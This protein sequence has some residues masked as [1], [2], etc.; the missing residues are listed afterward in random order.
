MKMYSIKNICRV[1]AWLLL[2]VVTCC[3]SL[4][5]QTVTVSA[6]KTATQLANALTGPGVTISN[7]TLNCPSGANGTFS[8]ASSPLLINNGILLTTGSA[9]DVSNPA[10][11]FENTNNNAAGDASLT[12]LSGNPTF[13]ACVLEFDFVPIGDSI[14]FRYQFASEEY[15]NYTCTE[16][17]DV[18]G[19]FISGPGYAVPTNIARVPGTMVPVAINSVNGGTPTGEGELTN[20]TAMGPGSP[21]PAYFVNNAS[22]ATM[23]YDG[24]T[25]VLSA[26]AAVTPC[27]TYHFKLGVAD[28][29]DRVLSS[30]VFIEEGSLAILP[31]AITNCPAN[32]TLYAGTTAGSCEKVAT[33]TPPSVSAATCLNVTS[34]SSHLPGGLFKVGTTPVTYSFTNAGGTS[35]CTFNVTV[36]DTVKPVAVCKNNIILNLDSGMGAVTPMMVNNGSSDNCGIMSMTVTPAQFTCEDAGNQTVTLTVTDSSGNT[37]TCTTTVKVRYAPSCSISVMPSSNTYTGGIPTNIYLGYGPQKATIKANATGGTG[38]TYSWSPANN[39][40][41]TTCKNPVFKPTA[42]GTYVYEVTVT[43]SNGCSTTCSVVF[44]VKD[45]RVP[46]N[47]NHNN[48]SW[49]NGWWC[50]GGND[51]WD[52]DRDD[53]GCNDNDKVYLCHKPKNGNAQ[54]LSVSTNAVAAHLC[55]HMGDKLG[56]CN[57]TCSDPGQEKTT[58]PTNDGQMTVIEEQH[59]DISAYP[60]PFNQDVRVLITGGTEAA[61]DLL[62]YDQ[63]GRLI[64]QLPA[65][66]TGQ[67]IVLG[68]NLATGIYIIEVKNGDVSKKIKVIKL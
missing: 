8:G 14:R 55:N 33:W 21:F 9:A 4:Q 56:K 26:R 11:Y 35:T 65:Q 29:S 49:G 10:S 42:A 27:S 61:A 18:F 37:A 60:N 31:P 5:A 13:D 1:C 44:C 51:R 48:N 36:L 68:R 34:Q 63:L 50:W 2:P 57:E 19:F 3:N 58:P 7:A 53:W 39:L 25:T 43:N 20:C 40:S 23:A 17:N 16:F 59:L 24:L 30:G 32:I 66:P 67:E 47:N 41:C 12:T 38:F 28:A 54:L 62:V 52:D 46:S 64:D 22:G 6:N 15:P 45:I